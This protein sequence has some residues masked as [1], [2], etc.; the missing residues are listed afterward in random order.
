MRLCDLK[1]L[2]VAFFLLFYSSILFP[3]SNSLTV[4]QNILSNRFCARIALYESVG[5]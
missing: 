2:C 3:Y 4:Q 1:N 5:I